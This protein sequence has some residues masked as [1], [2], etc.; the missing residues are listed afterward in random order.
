MER[1]VLRLLEIV[2]SEVHWPLFGLVIVLLL[3]GAT[4]EGRYGK[5]GAFAGCIAVAVICVGIAV[6][7]GMVARS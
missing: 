4:L 5:S 7:I 1:L 6:G 3:I 2:P